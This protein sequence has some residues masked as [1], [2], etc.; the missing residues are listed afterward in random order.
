M[1]AGSPA[2]APSPV[3]ALAPGRYRAG[4]SNAAAFWKERWRGLSRMPGNWPVRFLGEETVATPS[5]YP[6]GCISKQLPVMLIL[7]RAG[8]G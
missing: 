6:T 2:G 3:R 4:D 1:T 8:S 7:L 5:P